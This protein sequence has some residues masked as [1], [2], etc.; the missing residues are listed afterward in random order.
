VKRTY[1]SLDEFEEI[2]V[3]YLEGNWESEQLDPPLVYFETF[4]KVLILFEKCSIVDNDLRIRNT[5]LQDFVIHG[6]C[7]FH[8]PERLLEV[9]VERPKF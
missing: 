8:G 6:L 5:K 9:D 7:G 3:P 1:I 4:F 2:N